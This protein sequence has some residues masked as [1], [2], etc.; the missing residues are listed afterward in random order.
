METYLV[1]SGFAGHVLSVFYKLLQLPKFPIPSA[2]ASCLQRLFPAIK[3][4][5][6]SNFLEAIFCFLI[7]PPMSWSGYRG[8]SHKADLPHISVTFC[9]CLRLG[10]KNHRL[11]YSTWPKCPDATHTPPW[12]TID[13]FLFIHRQCH[14]CGIW[15]GRKGGTCISAHHQYL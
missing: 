5:T 15:Q 11:H 10:V 9:P 13:L 12:C 6:G 2:V 3:Q 7:S 1:W 14:F 4:A 8:S